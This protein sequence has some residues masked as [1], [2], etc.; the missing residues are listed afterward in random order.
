MLWIF[1]NDASV[2]G[3]GNPWS[4]SLSPLLC[5]QSESFCFWLMS[6]FE[7]GVRMALSCMG[8]LDLGCRGLLRWWLCIF[9]RTVF[10]FF[11]IFLS[12]FDVAYPLRDKLWSRKLEMRDSAG[13]HSIPESG[14]QL[15]WRMLR[16]I[17][18]SGKARPS[19]RFFPILGRLLSVGG[20]FPGCHHVTIIDTVEPPL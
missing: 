2:T 9:H 12:S 1:G 16:L 15:A 4:G 10:L 3:A 18:V 5:N 11:G 19:C 13:Y 14:I 20:A 6:P 17:L 7:R 8:R